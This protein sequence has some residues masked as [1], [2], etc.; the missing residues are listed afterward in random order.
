MITDELKF[1]IVLYD[2]ECSLCTR[3]RQGIEMID[4]NINFHFLSIHSPKA[5]ELSL[6]FK[7]DSIHEK[8][9]LIDENFNIHI[10]S[11]AIT[12]MTS[13]LPAVSKFTW[14]LQ[15]DIGKKTSDFFYDKVN[16]IRHSMIEKDCHHCSKKKL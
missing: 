10:G 2:S 1:P 8:M 15:T 6:H 14:L 7:L 12:F 9:H 5:K 13:K 4:K 16:Q 11:D 3:F